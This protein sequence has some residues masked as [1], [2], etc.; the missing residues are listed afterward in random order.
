MRRCLPFQVPPIELVQPLKRDVTTL[1]G[2]EPGGDFLPRPALLPLLADEGHKRF[3]AAAISASAAPLPLPFT[4]GF[5][6]HSLTV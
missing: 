5:Q 6:I 4:F 3:E 1:L 2:A